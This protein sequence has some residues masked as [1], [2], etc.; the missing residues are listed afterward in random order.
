[1]PTCWRRSPAAI[2]AGVEVLAVADAARDGRAPTASRR[3]RAS[4]VRRARLRPWLAGQRPMHGARC[5]RARRMIYTSGTT[6]R[7]KGVRRQRRPPEQMAR[8]DACA[9]TCSASCPACAAP[10]RARSTTPR[11]TR[12]PCAPAASPRLM[13]LMPR[14]DPGEP[15]GADRA[16]APRHHVH[17]ADHVHPAAQ[18]ARG[19][20]RAATTCP[21]CKFVIHAAAPCP[22]EVKRA[23]IDWWGP[24]IN[25]FYGST[26]IERRDASPP[27]PT[28]WPSPARWAGPCRARELRILDDDG[29]HPA[30]PAR[31]ARSSRASPSC[32]TSP[33]TTCPTSA[34]R[35]TATASSPAAT[36][37]ISTRTA[38]CSCATASATW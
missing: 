16:R 37:A 34:P 32:P 18:A 21:R 31:S 38:T 10:C 19:G 25:E 30:A 11:P 4:A 24:V 1:M 15:A 33:T 17:G 7:P 22:H 26:E 5:R 14:F 23:M 3:C 2:P 8:I 20:A 12:L 29:Q 9:A 28:R 6:G 35:S 13:V 36:S 27:A